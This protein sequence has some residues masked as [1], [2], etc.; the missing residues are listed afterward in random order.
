[1]RKKKENVSEGQRIR[2]LAAEAKAKRIKKEKEIATKE[3]NKLATLFQKLAYSLYKEALATIKEDA[4]ERLVC[5]AN[6]EGECY[7]SLKDLGR[8]P[9]L[10]KLHL[11]DSDHYLDKSQQ[12]KVVE[13]LI[14]KLEADGFK[15]KAKW[16]CYSDYDNFFV[17]IYF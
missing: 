11:R 1:M 13:L 6:E 17:T 5:P 14:K 4:K 9:Y 2:Q 16:E 15:A 3:N 8:E 12:K 7:L 10:A